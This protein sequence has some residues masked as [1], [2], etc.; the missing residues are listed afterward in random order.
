MVRE[1]STSVFCHEICPFP[2]RR[3]DDISI[4]SVMVT[5]DKH[6]H[7]VISLDQIHDVKGSPKP[8]S[9]SMELKCALLPRPMPANVSKEESA[10]LS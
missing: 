10:R 2:K 4:S 9:E 1:G 6:P 8:A 5:G 7:M 3:I